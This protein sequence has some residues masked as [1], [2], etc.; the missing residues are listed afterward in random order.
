[1]R[2][3]WTGK[4]SNKSILKEISP[5]Y[6]LEGLVQKLK[7]QYFA[8]LMRGANSLEKTLMLGKIEGKRRRGWQR[9]RWIDSITNS[10]NIYLSKLWEILKGREAW[11]AAVSGVT[12]SQTWPSN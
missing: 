2:V 8:H 9:M 6:S 11:R 4:R 5:E 3:S 12:N 7:L 10:M 1:L